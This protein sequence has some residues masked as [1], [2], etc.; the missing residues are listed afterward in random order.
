M[1]VSFQKTG[2]AGS[3]SCSLRIGYGLRK[4]THGKLSQQ[5]NEAQTEL[6]NSAMVP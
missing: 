2:N 6:G 1:N 5:A 4:A 3:R